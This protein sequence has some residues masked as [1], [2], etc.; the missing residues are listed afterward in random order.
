DPPPLLHGAAPPLR[1]AQRG[2]VR[3]GRDGGAVLVG[4]EGARGRGRRPPPHPGP[5]AGRLRAERAGPGTM[6]APPPPPPPRAHP[7]LRR[8][9]RRRQE[10]RPLPAVLRREGD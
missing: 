8:L 4:V 2:E 3:D 10:G 1:P 6:V 9:R 5:R 7:A